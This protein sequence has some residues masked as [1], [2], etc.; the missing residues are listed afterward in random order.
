MNQLLN[1]LFGI[2]GGG[3][4][5]GER[6]LGFGSPDAQLSFV[7]P[8]PAWAVVLIVLGLAAL[9]WWS[10]RKLPGTRRARALLAGLRVAA[11]SVLLLVILGPRIEQT[12][13]RTEPDWA[14]VLLDRSGS[15]ATA[16]ATEPGS[17]S[18]MTRKAQQREMIDASRDAWAALAREKRVVW[19]G[20]GDRA[21]VLATGEPPA[22]G[23][24]DA[25]GGAGGTSTNIGIAI[26]AALDQAVARPVSAIVLASD[27][28]SFDTIDP[29]LINELVSAQIPI[30]A[31]P[32][33]SAGPVR[34][35][36]IAQVQY[37]DAVF[38]RDIVPVRVRLS[39]SGFDDNDLRAA[40]ARVELVDHATGKV[41]DSV[42]ITAQ[43]LGAG[44]G[45]PQ[46]VSMTHTPEGTGQRRLDVRIALDAG[47]GRGDL[48]ASNDESALRFTIVARPMRVLYVDGYPRWEQR[49][50]KNLLLREPSIVSSTL[51][52]SSSRRYIQEGDE[53]ISAMPATPQEWEPF[54]VV[55]I[56]DV[57]PE[58]FS[59]Q[60]LE[61][62]LG[63]VAS[64]GAG[65]LWAAG[66]ASTPSGWTSTAL[67]A[68]LPVRA[69]AGGSQASTRVWDTPVTMR[70]SEEALRL[71]VLGL[72]EDRRG[73]PE[74]L[75]DPATGWSKLR[76]ALEMDDSSFKPGVSVLATATAVD[77]DETAPIVTM[78]RY[79]AG[80]SVLVG[81]D[82]IWRWRYGLGEDLPERFWLPLIRSLGRGTVE[83]R[84]APA[85]LSVTPQH[86]APGRPAQV[87]LRLFDQAAIDS[88]PERVMVTITPS[89]GVD[90]AQSVELR[91]EGDGRT[92]TWVPEQAGVYSIT[93][94]GLDL[95]LTQI[96]GEARVLD[97]SDEGRLLD[98]DHDLLASL[99]QQTGGQVVMPPDFG[100]IPDLL[101][102][103]T[104][105]IA[106]PARRASLW[107]RRVVLIVLV[108][109]LSAEWIGRRVLRLA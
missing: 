88:V 64:H 4:V 69:D 61:S 98:T 104:R 90:P 73:W 99:A 29:D 76:W 47:P 96:Q 53:L 49:Y 81:T 7:H 84:A 32:L 71:G 41:L 100:S 65:V 82:E 12:T 80:R 74:R 20:F 85:T 105:T 3:G 79:G 86:P 89:S 107:D 18:L 21:T 9:V 11:L 72:G 91:G 26:R 36:G 17:G 94:A 22:P 34:D 55:I 33:G 87:T 93:P 42:P 27:G 68:L 10:Y 39:G 16:D 35:I 19:M 48:N 40:R 57:R 58:M 83:R 59:R 1:W 75:S 54:D 25:T 24:L 97:Q 31:V 28:R 95:A 101:P 103:R 63:H 5:D 8:L 46:W 23:V 50:L 109:L 78:M 67:G 102:N 92:G 30:I 70:A 77:R 37:P 45:D 108:V 38:G 56:G 106:S 62:L 6:A 51:M 14:M 43:E 44:G 13:I 66:P 15:M 52:L 2:G 60:Q